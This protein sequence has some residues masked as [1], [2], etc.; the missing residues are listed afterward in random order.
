MHSNGPSSPVKCRT[1]VTSTNR[2]DARPIRAYWS[3][4]SSFLATFSKKM[5]ACPKSGP[6]ILI[7]DRF[8]M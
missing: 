8:G 7:E 3:A 2:V 4:R 1:G 6:L 5:S